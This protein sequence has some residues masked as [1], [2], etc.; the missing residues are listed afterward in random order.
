VH[1][2]LTTRITL[3]L[4][5]ACSFASSIEIVLHESGHAMAAVLL[6]ADVGRFDVHP[7][8]RSEV[9]V[10][11]DGGR[12]S[13]SSLLFSSAGMLA[14]VGVAAGVYFVTRARSHFWLPL[15]CLLPWSLFAEGS[16]LVDGS[17]N[18]YG[19]PSS[20][21]SLAYCP[22]GVLISL[23]GIMF[24]VA[25]LLS[26]NL[27]A[28]LGAGES[29]PWWARGLAFLGMAGVTLPSGLCALKPGDSWTMGTIVLA[30]GFGGLVVISITGGL[31]AH[32]LRKKLSWLLRTAD[33]PV[34]WRQTLA[35]LAAG[36]AVVG[37]LLA[38]GHTGH[39]DWPLGISTCR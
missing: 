17:L 14:A 19:D 30:T 5:G 15:Q 33:A 31:I 23:G 2:A 16:Y 26:V 35:A 37:L 10:S 8:R 28:R 6:G 20:I 13:E 36:L 12:R 29:A 22:Q 21:G 39:A 18:N 25:I 27:I 9:A 4:L 7:Y 24:L 3:A 11:Y 38:F 32:G 34:S 1:A